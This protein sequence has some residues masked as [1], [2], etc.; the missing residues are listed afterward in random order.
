MKRK[1][2][3]HFSLHLLFEVVYFT[4]AENRFNWRTLSGP[5][6]WTMLV[7]V[8]LLSC[9]GTLFSINQC[10]RCVSSHINIHNVRVVTTGNLQWILFNLCNILCDANGMFLC[11]FRVKKKKGKKEDAPKDHKPHSQK[12][13]LNVILKTKDQDESHVAFYVQADQRTG[14]KQNCLLW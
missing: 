4:E 3:C 11:L 2:K 13:K 9:P 10:V 6:K 5:T 8:G 12:Q 7:H 14:W 1:K